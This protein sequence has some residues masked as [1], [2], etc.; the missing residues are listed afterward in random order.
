MNRPLLVVGCTSTTPHGR[1][2]LERLVED[3]SARAFPVVGLDS[4]AALEGAWHPA[5]LVDAVPVEWDDEAALESFAAD[6][7]G[8][9]SAVL[10]HREQCVLPTALL[11]RW[12]DLAGNDPDAVRI[13]QDK[14]RCREALRVAGI[15]QPRVIAFNGAAANA[16][17]VIPVALGPGPWVVKPRVGMGSA[18]VQIVRGSES[19]AD[20]ITASRAYGPILVEEF[21][22]GSE[23]SCEGVLRNGV[24]EV[25]AVTHKMIDARCV[26]TGHRVPAR[27]D[28]NAAGLTEA[29]SAAF[30]ALGITRGL[31]H[32]EFWLG[33]ELVLGELHARP[34]GDFIHALVEASRPSLGLFGL[35]MDDLTGSTPRS[36]PAMTRAAGSQY[37]TFPM[38]VLGDVPNWAEATRGLLA[39]SLLV[40]PGDV[41]EPPTTSEERHAVLVAE[42]PTVADVDLALS[43][44]AAS[45]VVEVV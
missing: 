36:I 44:V 5:G 6:R 9:F 25:L 1:H 14:S 15:R 23:F 3:A 16:T 12:L 42:G 21:V 13:M 33:P 31:F 4:A 35:L 26:E 24:P 41:L 34:G 32:V 43:Q 10:T 37:L 7:A 45:L 29:V 18:G 8:Q 40:E 22:Q 11:A 19:L 27:L 30:R 20:A 39:S 17:T 38:G 28:A 2:A